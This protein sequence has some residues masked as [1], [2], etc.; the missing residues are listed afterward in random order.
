MLVAVGGPVPLDHELLPESHRHERPKQV[1]GLLDRPAGSEDAVVL[2]PAGE[3]A[4][5][6]S[7]ASQIAGRLPREVVKRGKQL[8]PREV[9]GGAATALSIASVATPRP[10]PA[11]ARWDPSSS[12]VLPVAWDGSTEPRRETP[13]LVIYPL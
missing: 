11:S 5:R 8:A 7:H 12:L 6:A 2:E 10:R 4:A 13:A 3:R 9:T 1:G